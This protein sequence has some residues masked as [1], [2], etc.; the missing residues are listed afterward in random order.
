LRRS[1]EPGLGFG[2]KLG[3]SALDSNFDDSAFAHITLPHCVTKLSWQNWDHAQWEDVWIY[4][5]HFEMSASLEGGKRTPP[6]QW[7][8]GVQV[9]VDH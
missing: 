7:Q 6:L 8:R 2:G 5:R 9:W 1:G 4:R 3:E